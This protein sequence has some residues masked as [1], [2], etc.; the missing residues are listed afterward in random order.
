[1]SDLT[2]KDIDLFLTVGVL[3]LSDWRSMSP[4]ERGH[5]VS[6][7]SEDAVEEPTADDRALASAREPESI[8]GIVSK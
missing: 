8:P 2:R 1:M 3:T 6:I 7:L 4:T 5:V